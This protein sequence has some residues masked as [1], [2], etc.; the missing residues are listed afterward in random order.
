MNT[1]P[2]PE[3]RQAGIT[4][5]HFIELGALGAAAASMGPLNARAAA[6]DP[7]Q[8]N[9]AADL[10][11]LTREENFVNVGRGK[12][13]PHELSDEKRRSVGL[14]RET[15]QLE[16]MPDPESNAQVER[17]LSKEAG[18]ALTWEQLM[19]LAEK[20]AVRFLHVISCTN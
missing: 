9:T 14:T 12:P 19:S 5:R 8:A 3:H 16:V 7:P 10:E 6:K 2:A 17:P 4:R 18:N 15:W 13:P 11:Y 20:K 1:T